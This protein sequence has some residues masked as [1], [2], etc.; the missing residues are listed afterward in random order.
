MN[1]QP[2][3]FGGAS[4]RD[5]AIEVVTE[6]SGEWMTRALAAVE[7]LPNNIKVT[8]EDVRFRLLESIGEP[9]HHNA[10]GAL[11]LHAVKDG[12]LLSTGIWRAMSDPRSHARRTLVYRTNT[13]S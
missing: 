12:S 3:F 9:H 6:N 13:L 1:Q 11:I 8:G 10:W 5:A 2:D 7:L 4:R